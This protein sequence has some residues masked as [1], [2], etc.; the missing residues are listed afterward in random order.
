MV[1][2]DAGEEIRNP[3]WHGTVDALQVDDLKLLARVRA[4]D[5]GRRPEQGAHVGQVEALGV[6][7]DLVDIDEIR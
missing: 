4:G 3:R 1:L 7:D 5:G 2:A 6:E